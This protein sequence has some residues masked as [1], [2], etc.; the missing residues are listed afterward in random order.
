MCIYINMKLTTKYQTSLEKVNYLKD[1][2]NNCEITC[3]K[4]QEQYYF[5]DLPVILEV[6]LNKT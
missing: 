1:S 3:K 2:V 6:N 5:S 4:Q